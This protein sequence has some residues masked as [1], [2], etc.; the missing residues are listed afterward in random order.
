MRVIYQI[1]HE[2]QMSAHRRDFLDWFYRDPYPKLV[3]NKE[4]LREITQFKC[5]AWRQYLKDKNLRTP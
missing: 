2:E 3:E 4:T 1:H 5:A